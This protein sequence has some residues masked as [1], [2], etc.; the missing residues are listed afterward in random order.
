MNLEEL[1]GCDGWPGPDYPGMEL[2]LKLEHRL[3]I[4]C[5]Y[6]LVH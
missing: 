2:K 5:V 3:G 4:V 1:V 6:T